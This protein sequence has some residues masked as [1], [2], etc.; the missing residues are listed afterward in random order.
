MNTNYVIKGWVNL[1]V[2]VA[3]FDSIGIN[4]IL[5]DTGEYGVKAMKNITQKNDVSH[6]L[7]DSV[8]WQ[9]TEDSSA[10][11][12]KYSSDDKLPTLHIKNAVEIGAGAPHALYRETMSTVHKTD[13]NSKEFIDSLKEWAHTKWGINPDTDS[14]DNYRF[15]RLLEVVRDNDTS[16]VPFVAPNV[17]KITNYAEKIAIVN[18]QKFIDLKNKQGGGK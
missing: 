16:G 14:Q 18:V 1:N 8:M 4:A 13:K 5:H 15:T 17:D 2:D 6:R 9:T 10:T 11:Q 12:G 3:D 7:T